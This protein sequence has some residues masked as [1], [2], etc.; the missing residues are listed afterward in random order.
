MISQASGSSNGS[1]AAEI[2]EYK[3]ELTEQK[4]LEKTMREREY[5][6]IKD[7]LDKTK[8]RMETLQLKVPPEERERLAAL[9]AA[10]PQDE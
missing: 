7:E 9:A 6:S 10:V 2:R 3:A 1:I 5:K 4:E 8:A